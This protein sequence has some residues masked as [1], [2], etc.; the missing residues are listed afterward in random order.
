MWIYT[1]FSWLWSYLFKVQSGKSILAL[2]VK[3]LLRALVLHIAETLWQLFSLLGEWVEQGPS[4][5][6]PL[7]TWETQLQFKASAFGLVYPGFGNH[8]AVKPADGIYFVFLSLSPYYS[9]VAFP[10]FFSLRKK[11]ITLL[12]F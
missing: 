12:P 3:L 6:S 2:Q 5:G 1:L 10:F 4:V 7:L 8:S 11:I 9:L